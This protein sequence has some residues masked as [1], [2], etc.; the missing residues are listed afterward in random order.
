MPRCDVARKERQATVRVRICLMFEPPFHRSV[1]VI[2]TNRNLVRKRLSNPNVEALVCCFQDLRCFVVDEYNLAVFIEHA[3]TVAD[4]GENVGQV[5][6]SHR[7]WHY[8]FAIRNWQ[9]E[10]AMLLDSPSL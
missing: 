9:F 3:K 5:G 10:C 6:R 1:E 8:K 4:L 7:N 2:E